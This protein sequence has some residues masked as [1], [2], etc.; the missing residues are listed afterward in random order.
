[1]KIL[2]YD[3]A[4][5]D[6]CAAFWWT[7]YEHMPYVHRP[8]GHQTINTPSIGPWYLSKT[9]QEGFRNAS[10]WLGDV[11]TEDSVFLA[12]DSGRVAGI[13][14]CSVDEEQRTG[15]SYRPI[16]CAITGDERLLMRFWAERLSGSE[17]G[18]H[19]VQLPLQV[20]V[21][22][23]RSSARFILRC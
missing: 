13:L 19:S 12:M 10:Y 17:I 21:V 14:V 8:D 9:L 20:K 22:Q 4:L 11:I 5:L 2:Q 6:E 16:C 23:W 1:M 7:I 18:G 15:K 3:D